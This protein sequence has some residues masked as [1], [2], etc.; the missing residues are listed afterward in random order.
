[1]SGFSDYRMARDLLIWIKEKTMITIGLIVILAKMAGLPMGMLL[2]IVI[3]CLAALL[4][5]FNLDEWLD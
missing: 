4:A 2:C 1:M 3:W 5:G